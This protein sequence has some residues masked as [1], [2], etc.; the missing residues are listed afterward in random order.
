MTGDLVAPDVHLHCSSP[1]Q[2]D[3]VKAS[4][5]PLWDKQGRHSSIRTRMAEVRLPRRRRA[6]ESSIGG[7]EG[8][9]ACTTHAR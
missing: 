5:V 9:P 8:D 2:L 1:T 3:G 6:E 4:R 7:Q